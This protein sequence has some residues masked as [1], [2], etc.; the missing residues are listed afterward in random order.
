MK[1][2]EGMNLEGVGTKELDKTCIALLQFD[3]SIDSLLQII[4][5][6]VK[7]PTVL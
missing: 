5:K 2:G 3:S 6:C 4:K 1:G 7:I